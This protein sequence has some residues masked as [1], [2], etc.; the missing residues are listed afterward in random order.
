[1]LPD[2]PLLCPKDGRELVPS[3]AYPYPHWYECPTCFALVVEP[4]WDDEDDTGELYRAVLDWDPDP[5]RH[6]GMERAAIGRGSRSSGGKRSR[7]RK[8]QGR[9]RYMEGSTVL[10]RKTDS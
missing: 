1:M 8:G 5:N 9:P 2:P 7:P 3:S 6:R 10:P 4:D